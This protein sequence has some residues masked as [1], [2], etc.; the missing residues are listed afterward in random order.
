MRQTETAYGNMQRAEF[1]EFLQWWFF[2]NIFFYAKIGK[3]LQMAII[4]HL[5]S[6][7]AYMPRAEI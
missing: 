5:A 4:M 1:Y 3:N 7:I 6:F 2:W